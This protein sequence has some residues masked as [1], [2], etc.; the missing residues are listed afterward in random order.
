MKKYTT[1]I[2]ALLPVILSAQN[3]QLHYDFG[4]QENG[5]K[6]HFLVGTF[7]F[8]RPD[9][10]G[11]TFFFT[12]FEF[13]SPDNPRGASSGYFEISRT[14]C[15]PW[16]QNNPIGKNFLLHIEYNDGSAIF[17]NDDSL[18]FGTNLY[19]SW[20]GGPEY[21]LILGNLSLNAMILYKYIRGSSAPDAQFTVVW[22]YPLFR[23][24]VSLSGYIDV[25]SQD[26]PATDSG[27]KLLILYAE[28][29]IWL[30]IN[31]HLSVGNETK[32]SKNF[33]EGSKRIEAFPTLG[34]KWE[35]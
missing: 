11:Y 17:A 16:L 32:I 13:N 14:F 4:K 33:I 18:T 15:L 9:T 27:N 5:F 34:V 3:I 31:R 28:P 30:N 22:N 24:K 19:S 8:F 26:N 7:E 2:P 23:N 10:L 25:W 21:G 1:L 35:F 29:Q 6:R 20:L 12:D